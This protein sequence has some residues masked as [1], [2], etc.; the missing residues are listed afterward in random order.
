MRWEVDR[1]W[2]ADPQGRG[3]QSEPRQ[4]G[5]VWKGCREGHGWH[6]LERCVGG[7]G[8]RLDEK[9]DGMVRK[10]QGQGQ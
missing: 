3:W 5:G 4:V 1:G 2:G 7:G 8:N 9:Q 6:G 10:R